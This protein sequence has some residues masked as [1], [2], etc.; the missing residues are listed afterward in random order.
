MIFSDISSLKEL[1]EFLLR[2]QWFQL[3]ILSIDLGNG[4]A[5]SRRQAITKRNVYQYLRR[6][7]A[8]IMNKLVK[9][10]ACKH[11]P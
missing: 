4:L 5:P 9:G 3:T 1:L 7:N 11:R 2:F 8:S 10:G 6:H